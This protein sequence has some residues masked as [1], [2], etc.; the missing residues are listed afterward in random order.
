[1]PEVGGGCMGR[2][3]WVAGD[4]FA[5]ALTAPMAPKR[6]KSCLQWR[7]TGGIA[8]CTNRI[9]GFLALLSACAIFS[10]RRH[11]SHLWLYAAGLCLLVRKGVA[12]LPPFPNTR[13]PGCYSV[14]MGLLWA[15]STGVVRASLTPLRRC[16]ERALL[17][18]SLLSG[19]R[20][21]LFQHLAVTQCPL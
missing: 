14:V 16:S 5:D 15:D 4:G 6:P 11:P 10:G 21:S 2:T 18:L 9:C 12:L 3:G 17:V 1:M 7:T 8:G 19:W 20:S 13:A